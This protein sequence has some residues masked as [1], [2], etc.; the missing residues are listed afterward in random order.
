MKTNSKATTV[1]SRQALRFRRLGLTFIIGALAVVIL[2]PGCQFLTTTIPLTPAPPAPAPASS[3]PIDPNW[4]PPVPNNPSLD[5]AW[6]PVLAQV[7][8]SVVAINA[9]VVSFGVT[10]EVAGSGW[11]IDANGL[12]VTNNHVISGAQDI[13]ISLDDGRA[14]TAK[15]I[16]ADPT[17]D[18][19][20][21]KVESTDLPAASIGDSSELKPGMA[22]AAI[23]NALGE[24]TSMTG[25]WVSR[26]GVSVTISN[27]EMLYDLIETDA[28]INPGNSGG[29]LVDS[30]GDII[31]ITNAKLVGSSIEGVGYA[32]SINSA[33]PIIQELINQGYVIRPWLG[34]ALQTVTVATQF[35]YQ[36][37][38]DQGARITPVSANSPASKAGL[39]IGDVI[40]GID[41][42]VVTSSSD[43]TQEI[44]TKQIGDKVSI[45]YLRG[46]NQYNAEVTLEASPPPS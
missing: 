36:L 13:T 34:A 1:G 46:N 17:T 6:S 32:I 39:E 33:I 15:Q 35:L 41:G 9:K 2:L 24:G 26:L 4:T 5:A 27:N 42:K 38:V 14:F 40:I 22:V 30:A 43:V 45:D 21:I 10:E 12:I 23:G 3:P 18:L 16:A 19:A 28:A 31:G 37:S 25:G 44:A 20:V 8:P 11:V 29:P 7:R